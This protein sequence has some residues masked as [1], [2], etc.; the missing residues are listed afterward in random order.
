VTFFQKYLE[1]QHAAQSGYAA[2]EAYNANRHDDFKAEAAAVNSGA[3]YRSPQLMS[4]GS[5]NYPYRFTR[6][7]SAAAAGSH[8]TYSRPSPAKP[9]SMSVYH[10]SRY[11]TDYWF[12]G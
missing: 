3:E 7:T 2:Y 10:A 1:D 5:A 12:F 9:L 8:S 4:A 6:F 11:L